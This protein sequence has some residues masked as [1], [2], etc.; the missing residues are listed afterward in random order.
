MGAA[1]APLNMVSEKYAAL[2]RFYFY[3]CRHHHHHHHH[4][5][6]MDYNKVAAQ[7]ISV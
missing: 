6:Q 2:A 7:I 3:H 4:H 1:L 5:R